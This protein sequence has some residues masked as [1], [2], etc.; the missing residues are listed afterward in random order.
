VPRSCAADAFGGPDAKG[1]TAIY[2]PRAGRDLIRDPICDYIWF[3]TP[4]P[5]E[6]VAES[7]LVNNPWVQRLRRIR[8]LQTAWIVYPGATHSRF[9]HSLGTMHVAGELAEQLAQSLLVQAAAAGRAFV[10]DLPSIPDIVETARLYGLLHD[11]GHGPFGHLLDQ[12]WLRP[13]FGLTH[14]LI[15]AEIFRRELA[16]TIGGLK[17]GPGGPLKDGADTGLVELLITA[18]QPADS[19]PLWQH[20]LAQALSGPYSADKMD[21]IG[22]D[23]FYCGTPEYGKVDRRRLCL[24]S[25]IDLADAQG[26]AL[27]S[28]AEG[29]LAGFIA[30]RLSMYESV[31][32]HRAVRVVDVRLAELVP[33]ALKLLGIHDLHPFEHLDRYYALDEW[34]LHGS[35]REWSLSG[36]TEQRRFAREW[37]RTF[38]HPLPLKQAYEWKLA[39]GELTRI[40]ARALR[41]MAGFR[42]QLQEDIRRELPRNQRRIR[43][44]VD[45][46]ALDVKPQNPY[47]DRGSVSIF[48]AA[49]DDPTKGTF[50]TRGMQRLL[51]YLPV[52]LVACRVFAKAEH[53]ATVARACEAALPPLGEAPELQ[54]THH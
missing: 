43:F 39:P 9:S 1:A 51:A 15:G 36:T 21:Y 46:P 17:R 30:A 45:L 38:S 42:K 47:R 11:I 19:A 2:N 18:H 14:E 27:H 13:T 25:F 23:A 32:Y 12:V 33:H 6:T 16:E 8:Q 40:E 26:L 52:K 50:D 54:E 44:Q 31:Y 4:L 37:D 20:G 48:T 34:Y 28:S 22:R 53:V 24:H 3:T 35:I 41:D 10:R 49:P 5:G 7:T 29:A